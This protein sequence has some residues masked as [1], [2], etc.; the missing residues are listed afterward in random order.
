MKTNSI[1]KTGKAYTLISATIALLLNGCAWTPQFKD[2]KGDAVANSIA[3]MEEVSIGG[4]NQSL[5]IRGKDKNNPI[6]LFVHGGFGTPYSP[7]AHEFGRS[8]EEHF[9]VV[10]WDQRGGGKSYPAPAESIT[11]NQLLSDTHELVLHL[12]KRFDREKI[13][14]MGHS[15]GSYLGFLT[16]Q[17]YP[18]LFHAYIGT[19]QMVDFI[20]QIRIT[21]FWA[22]DE[23]KVRKNE[24][25]LKELEEVG[26]PPYINNEDVNIVW[27]WMVNF[28]GMLYGEE[29]LT[30][31][32]M[33][34]LKSPEYSLYDVYKFVRGMSFYSKAL[35]KNS[36]EDFWSPSI[37]TIK[38]MEVPVYFIM[39]QFDKNTHTQLAKAYFERLKAPK[40]EFFTLEDFGHFAFFKDPEVFSD[41]LIN[42]VL[43][44]NAH[45]ESS[46]K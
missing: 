15:W 19:G 34:V 30:P 9:V 3:L 32:I 38:E 39:G 1:K 46:K 14:L 11:Q 29:S 23:A 16:A 25:A 37:K 41:I 17:R 5:L 28:G 18:E 35:M 44:E 27:K 45:A 33:A 21:Y 31:L 7:M 12:L 8:W 22:L 24:G 43:K 20:E 26:P 36:G 6:L 40:K 13:F 4:V 2:A 10:H 42:R